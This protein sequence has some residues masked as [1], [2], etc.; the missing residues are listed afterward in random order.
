MTCKILSYVLPL[1]VRMGGWFLCDFCAML[2]RKIEVGI[3]VVDADS[4]R[5]AETNRA[6]D[7]KRA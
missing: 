1:S 6:P 3:R 4:N 5:V 2:S 7:F